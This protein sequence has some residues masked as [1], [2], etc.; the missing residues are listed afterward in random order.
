MDQTALRANDVIQL[1]AEPLAPFMVGAS[2][3][4]VDAEF[5]DDRPGEVE[6]AKRLVEYEG[7]NKRIAC[8]FANIEGAGPRHVVGAELCFPRGRDDVLGDVDP[9]V[10]ISA[11]GT[12]ECIGRAEAIGFRNLPRPDGQV[13][14]C[15]PNEHMARLDFDYMAQQD[16]L[17]LCRVWQPGNNVWGWRKRSLV[18]LLRHV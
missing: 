14:P 12:H 7:R 5:A 9:V 6:Q 13:I 1:A 10:G 11:I 16:T 15:S 18:S 2:E 8:A 17:Q 3:I 4:I